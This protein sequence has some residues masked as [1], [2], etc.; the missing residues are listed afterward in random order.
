MDYQLMIDSF[1]DKDSFI[2]YSMIKI[3][4]LSFF[5]DINA[6]FNHYHS[7]LYMNLAS[8]LDGMS[9]NLEY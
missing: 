9:L 5:K 1:Y 4:H 7:K 2:L 3:I 6:H 8:Y